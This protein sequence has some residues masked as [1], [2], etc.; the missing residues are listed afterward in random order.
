[1]SEKALPEKVIDAGLTAAYGPTMTGDCSAWVIA[2]IAAVY[3]ASLEDAKRE[4]RERVEALEPMGQHGVTGVM[5][6]RDAV[7]RIFD[8]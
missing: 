6:G 1:V 3:W 8:A 4:L 2:L 5:M 7:L